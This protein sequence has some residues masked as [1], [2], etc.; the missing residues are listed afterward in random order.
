VSER[1]SAY[2]AAVLAGGVLAGIGAIGLNAQGV[3]IGPPPG[4]L[5][6]IGGRRLHILCE[7]TGSP[8]V[9][10]EAGAGAFAID[11]TLVQPRIGRL[12][13]T[14]SYD[15][16]RYGWSDP[17][18]SAE[19]PANVVRDLHALLDAAGERPPFVMVG[20]SMGG[21][22]VRIFELRYPSEVAG[23][24]LIDPVHEDDLF[25]M[26]EGKAVTIGSLSAEQLQKTMPAG[27]VTVQRREVQTGT[28]F[29]RLPPEVYRIRMELE[30]RLITA[31]SAAPVAHAVVVEAMEGQRA[32]LAE[33]QLVSKTPAYLGS[34]P[35][36]VL[37]RGLESREGL[38]ASHAR[39]ARSST[40]SRHAIIADSGHEVQL[41]RPEVVTQAIEDVL[42]AVRTG[43][44]LILR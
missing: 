13:R 31:D 33:L 18:P 42:D 28:P 24:V 23:L 34:R 37:T 2:I 10:L 22:Y 6:D 16:A 8:T 4:K 7:G 21:I 32:A 25:T 36:V 15:R 3:D 35:L 38:R 1:T 29:D 27:D 30:R 12:T 39:L 43:R 20:H 9:V 41:Y 19:M 14:C 40:N 5:V 44:A 26:F 17:S 11:W